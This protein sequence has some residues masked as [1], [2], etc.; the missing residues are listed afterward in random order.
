MAEKIT[1]KISE[2]NEGY[3]VIFIKNAENETI[4]GNRCFRDVIV[5]LNEGG[6]NSVSIDAR[7]LY[8]FLKSVYE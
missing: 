3:S 2:Y 8:E 1:T 5:A 7:E 6:F 4:G